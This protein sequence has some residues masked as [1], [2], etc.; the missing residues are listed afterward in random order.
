[1]AGGRDASPWLIGVAWVWA[2]VHLSYPLGLAV[3]GCH[4]L[5][6]RWPHAGDPRGGP[7][8]RLAGIGLAAVAVS[9]LNPFGW[10]ALWQPF[11]YLLTLRH[12]IIFLEIGEL[13]PV[14]WASNVWNGL[15]LLVAAW[16]LLALWR[17]R[18][19]GFDR[20]ETFM[21]VTF[22]GIGLWSQRFLGFLAIAAAPYVARDLDAWLAGARWRAA[23]RGRRRM[24]PAGRAAVAACAC[25]A[26]SLPEWLLSPYTPGLGFSLADMPVAA[27]DFMSA[28]GVRGRG[29]NPFHFGGY[30]LWRF[31]PERARLPFM[32]IHQ[33]GTPEDR[34][35]AGAAFWDAAAYRRLMAR[36]AFDYALVDRETPAQFP[37]LDFFDRDPTWTLVFTDDVAALYVRRAGP[38]AAIADSF[39]YR[40]W[41][42]GFGALGPLYRRYAADSSWRALADAELARQVASSP[43]NATARFFTANLALLEGRAG[44]AERE[45]RAALAVAPWLPRAHFHL[46]TLALDAGRPREAAR[47][48]EREQRSDDHGAGTAMPIARAWAQYGD[49]EQARRWYRRALRGPDGPAARDSLATLE[50]GPKP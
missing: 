46:G 8:L 4:A 27:C 45:L 38:L 40:A 30:L 31:W 35:L 41:P 44:D 17:W 21:L 42:A 24:A 3:L 34:A 9:F 19:A 37:M 36:H 29:Y 5:D 49:R 6:D 13:R 14:E 11:E 26:L 43:R 28:H 33:T 47:E 16:P 50:R 32:D 20:V 22:I 15:P 1:R 12:E 18:R 48:F 23:L 25:V 10:R 2:N 39:A 7:R